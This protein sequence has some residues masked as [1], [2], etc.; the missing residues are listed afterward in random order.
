MQ[1]STYN[2]LSMPNRPKILILSGPSGSG[3]STLYAALK[4]YIPDLYF[5]IST[6]TRAPRKGE[7]HGR[8]YYFC[9]KQDF[10]EGIKKDQFLEWAKVH[11]N[12]YGTSKA[13]V[14]NALELGKLVLF[15]VDIQGHRNIKLHYPHAKSIFITTPSDIILKERLTARA[16]DA[17]E[18]IDARLKHAYEEMRHIDEFDYLIIN[19]HIDDSKDQILSIAKSLECATFNAKEIYKNWKTL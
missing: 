16:S 1:K 12:Y 17:K 5:S 4:E 7:Q 3:K 6:T 18:V 8:E 15:D 2:W 19:H 11:D 10:E 9:D 14:Q 13:P